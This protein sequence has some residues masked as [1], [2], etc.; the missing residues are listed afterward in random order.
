MTASQPI[1]F[2]SRNKIREGQADEFRK[3]YQGSVPPIIAGKAG[4][5]AQLAYENE[6]TAEVTIVRFF[7]DAD[8]LDLQIEGAD[9][10]SQKT[11]EFIE[12]LSLE[13]FGTPNPGTLEMLRRIAGPGVTV[14]ISPHYMGGFIR[15]VETA[16]GGKG[17]STV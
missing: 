11:Y 6:E 15:Q 14:S 4:T 3:H 9:E 1:V 12:P 7:A 8:A 16:K 17:G 13:I 10:R 2:I 5:L